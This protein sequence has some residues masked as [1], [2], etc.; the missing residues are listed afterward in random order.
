MEKKERTKYYPLSLKEKKLHDRFVIEQKINGFR[1]ADRMIEHLLSLDAKNKFLEERLT[2]KEK[3]F[4]EL[5]DRLGEK[6]DRI[7]ELER[8]LKES[9]K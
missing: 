3:D 9:E 1:N 7:E 6:M 2:Q 5:I 8:Q 4:N